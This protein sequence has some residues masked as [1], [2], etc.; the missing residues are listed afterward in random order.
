MGQTIL[1]NDDSGLDTR[2]LKE[3][4]TT[5]PGGTPVAGQNRARQQA[6][7]QPPLG[8]LLPESVAMNERVLMLALWEK[9]LEYS[10]AAFRGGPQPINGGTLTPGMLPESSMPYADAVGQ[11]RVELSGGIAGAEQDPATGTVA[12]HTGISADLIAHRTGLPTPHQEP[13][14]IFPFRPRN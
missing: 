1:N 11:G 14:T 6:W 5:Y 7:R 9:V 12:E 10:D 13:A 8:L 2:L 4:R 3:C